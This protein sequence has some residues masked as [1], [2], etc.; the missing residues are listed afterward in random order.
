MI[1][2]ISNSCL[3]I[4]LLVILSIPSCFL[5][6]KRIENLRNE[7]MKLT[8]ER[9]I[10]GYVLNINQS[11][12]RNSEKY[13]NLKELRLYLNK[14]MTF[15]FSNNFPFLFDTTGKWR[16]DNVGMY[17]YNE[18]IYNRDRRII[19]QISQCCTRSME[20]EI[21]YPFCNLSADQVEK[22]VFT[23]EN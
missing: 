20:I 2:N 1:K 14:D 12:I 6:K 9:S 22:L 18:L 4:L 8:T 21:N 17:S 19:D 5:I 11:K 23:K 13:L 15:R 7:E 10:G 3:L 16:V